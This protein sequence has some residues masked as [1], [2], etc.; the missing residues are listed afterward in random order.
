MQR[1]R[2]HFVALVAASMAADPREGIT[3][4]AASIDSGRAARVLDNLIAFTKGAVA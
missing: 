4:A 2:K 1:L 3:L